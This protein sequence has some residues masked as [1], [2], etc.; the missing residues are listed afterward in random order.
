MME[1]TDIL[2]GGMGGPPAASELRELDDLEELNLRSRV[3]ELKKN[4]SYRFGKQSPLRH[5]LEQI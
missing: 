1:G 3:L 5:Y 2:L 4:S